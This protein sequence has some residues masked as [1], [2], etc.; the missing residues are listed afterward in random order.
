MK[1]DLY[2]QKHE[3]VGTVELADRVFGVRWNPALVHQAFVTES[4]NARA[5]VAHT[6]DRGDVRGGGKK[7]WQQKHTGRARHGSIR[8]PLW[9]GGGAT[10]G[11]RNERI[12]KKKINKKMKQGALYSLLSKKFKDERVKIIDSLTFAEPKTKTAVSVLK[13]FFRGK[14]NALLV[15]PR[16]AENTIRAARNI[17]HVSVSPAAGLNITKCLTH[18]LILFDQKAVEELIHKT[19]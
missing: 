3:K 15:T 17:P 18:D 6:K 13:H 9:R 8:S 11:P 14:P 5:P 19:T 10:F 4:A 12:Y 1:A 2:N 7:P 16:D